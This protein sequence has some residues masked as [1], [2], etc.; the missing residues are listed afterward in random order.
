[1]HQVPHMDD[2]AKEG[3]KASGAD[4]GPSRP[5][6]CC[7]ARTVKPEIPRFQKPAEQLGFAA[8]PQ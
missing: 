5:Y 7:R 3:A 2:K 8:S 6:Q 1:M 4:R